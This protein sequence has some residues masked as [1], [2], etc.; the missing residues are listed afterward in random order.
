[1]KSLQLG[2]F[3]FFR[4][5]KTGLSA[6]TRGKRY[7]TLDG[8]NVKVILVNHLFRVVLICRV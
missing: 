5:T 8:R 6:F 3:E 4:T 7:V 2:P 1:M